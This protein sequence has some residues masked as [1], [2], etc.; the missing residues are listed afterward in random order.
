MEE[1]EHVA[2]EQSVNLK[3]QSVLEGAESSAVG[4]LETA[5]IQNLKSDL[6]TAT[7]EKTSGSPNISN[8][9]EA[10]HLPEK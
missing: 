7:P 2:S 5:G 1:T 8:S 3:V 6:A 10:N 4:S 9:K